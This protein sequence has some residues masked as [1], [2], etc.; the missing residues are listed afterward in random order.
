MEKKRIVKILHLETEPVEA[1]II[2]SALEVGGVP[3][4]IVRVTEVSGFMKHLTSGEFDVVFSEIS[5]GSFHGLDA[6]AAVREYDRDLP[7]IFVSQKLGEDLTAEVLRNG[8]T[9]YVRKQRLDRLARAV[10][11]SLDEYTDKRK[12]RIA[13]ESV[14]LFERAVQQARESIIITKAT[15]DKPG[16]E[17]IYTNPAFTK[18][19]GYT[20]EEVLGKSPRIL[21]GPKTSRRLLARLKEQL[22]RGEQFQA[23]SI[24]Y[25]K[26]GTEFFIDYYIDPLRDEHGKV[27]H[28]VAIQR[29]ITDR[30]RAEQSLRAAEEKYRS[31]FENATEGIFQ[32]TAD[33]RFLNANVALARM[34]GF[35]TPMHL[36]THFTD[37]GKQ[38]YL[39]KNRR[40]EFIRTMQERDFVSDFESQV[41]RQDGAVI[42]ISEQARAVRNDAGTILYYEGMVDDIT[43]RKNAQEQIAEQAALLDKA[44]DAILVLNLD[45]TIRFWNSAATKVYGWPEEAIMGQPAEKLMDKR[46]TEKFLQAL[47]ITLVRGEWTGELR[48]LTR[49]EKEIVVE[50]RWSLVRNDYGEAKSILV[51]NSDI[52]ERKKLEAQFLQAQRMES[53][54]MLAG[55]IAHDLNNVLSPI[56]M[57]S[58]FLRHKLPDEESRH[59]ISTLEESAQRG[60]DLV[61]QVLS[62]ARGIDSE[63]VLV[64]TRHIM[65]EIANMAK[66]TFPKSV[67]IRRE[68]QSDLWAVLGDSTQLHQVLL[69]FCVNARDAMPSGGTISITGHNTTLTEPRSQGNLTIDPGDYV[70]MSVSDTGTGIP[71]DV[72][73]RIFEPFFTTKEVGKGTGLGLSTVLAIV[74]S[75]GGLI[76][77]ESTLGKGTTFSVYLPAVVSNVGVELDSATSLP[78]GTGETILLVDDEQAIREITK[79]TLESFNYTVLCAANG[80]EAIQIFKDKHEVI[81]LA[82]VDLMMPHMDGHTTIRHLHEIRADVKVITVSGLSS[83]ET[84]TSIPGVNA[85]LPKP[86]SLGNLLQTLQD[87]LT[88]ESHVNGRAVVTPPRIAAPGSIALVDT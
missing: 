66:Q 47:S 54:G 15:L 85:F 35:E 11:R 24:N 22:A 1:D 12:R 14:R 69:N 50:S 76:E 62:F 82:L 27:T 40:A 37:L 25:K 4:E 33:G 30:K 87:V 10:Q 68:I 60:A 16:P 63:R 39:D 57:A 28:F 59:V 75:H 2:R 5:A 26:D 61:K 81:S 48:Q 45:N 71:D 49:D 67:H 78:I 7:F 3:C 44:Q 8:A 84:L 53:I 38:L 42:W 79:E 52:T 80:D 58:D 9:D 31:I 83:E 65:N 74:K 41:R 29:D 13:E 34:F 86:F 73:I 17:I 43:H 70:T 64:Q 6:L 55:G 18:M 88:S 36:M 46:D 56:L 72:L 32:T 23:E 21:Q 20:A 19:T 51:L 77:V